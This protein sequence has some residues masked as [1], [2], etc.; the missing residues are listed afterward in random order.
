MQSH[1]Y[2]VDMWRYFLGNSLKCSLSVRLLVLFSLLVYFLKVTKK[3]L[4]LKAYAATLLMHY[5]KKDFK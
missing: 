3:V 5:N 2:G 4:F 1:L